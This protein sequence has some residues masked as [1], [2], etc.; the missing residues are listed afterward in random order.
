M[1]E[2]I[3]RRALIATAGTAAAATVAGRAAAQEKNS[4]NVLIVGV[5]CSP[6]KGMTT[7][8]ATA[9]ALD[10][11]KSVN[12]RIQT[13]IIDLGGIKIASPDSPDDE[14]AAVLDTLKKPEFGGMIIGSPTYFRS[15]SAL[16]KTF[17]ERLTVLR[18]PTPVLAGKPVGALC[19]G[20]Y[21]NGGQELVISQIITA[22]LCHETLA[23]GGRSPA[24]QG[25]TLWNNHDDD[26]TKDELG[27]ESAKK[28][29]IRVAEAALH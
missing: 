27:M 3:S 1:K 26:I 5:S 2:K 24:Y 8:T 11:A 25:A 23:V 19:V 16:C 13:Q 20:G 12:P 29:G 15:L 28:L 21:R 6:R 7:A 22:M 14:F 10:A 17:I 18:K 9:A 4:G